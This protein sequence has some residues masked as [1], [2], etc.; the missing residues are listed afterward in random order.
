MLAAY[1][2][3]WGLTFSS[4]S[5]YIQAAELLEQ[6]KDN[7]DLVLVDGNALADAV[8]FADSLDKHRLPLVWI[9]RGYSE[10]FVACMRKP[11]KENRLFSCLAAIRSGS[12]LELVPPSQTL[13]PVPVRFNSR[14]I[15]VVEDHPVNQKL[16]LLQLQ[17]LGCSVTVVSN[18]IE[19]IKAVCSSSYS[20]IFMDCQ[21]PEMD[22]FQATRAIRTAQAMSGDRD[23]CL[24]AGMDDYLTKP[25]NMKK[26]ETI[27]RRWLSSAVSGAVQDANSTESIM[28]KYRQTFAEWES[29][30]DRDTAEE[31]MNEF[32]QGVAQTSIELGRA[33]ASRSLAD[34]KAIAHRLKGLCLPF[35]ITEEQNACVELEKAIAEADWAKIDSQFALIEK[36]FAFLSSC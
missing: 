14:Q 30:M 33:I 26:L 10:R 3:D 16:A 5:S 22:G 20:L 2:Q 1:C 24:A 17:E 7:Y 29:S 8:A 35:Y 32:V 15:L 13:G 23:Q 21:M 27:L 31:L 19:A 4:A 34:V 36:S 6:N 25:V 18:G 9:G 28:K 11:I 12:G